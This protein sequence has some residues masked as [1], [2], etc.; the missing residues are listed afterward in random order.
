MPAQLK[1]LK[2][3]SLGMETDMIKFNYYGKNEEDTELFIESLNGY[4]LSNL[5]LHRLSYNDKYKYS[6]NDAYS[7][8]AKFFNS[9]LRSV[10]FNHCIFELCC[11]DK[12]KFYAGIS[13][14]VLIKNSSF[15][16]SSLRAS[17]Y[18]SSFK[19]C[20]F[21]NSDFFATLKKFGLKTTNL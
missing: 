19:M 11:F 21:T 14:R 18:E 10:I 8:N 16:N 5:H 3:M 2:L 12:T 13:R 17:F 7:H 15:C 1:M 6:F 20:Y 4:N 9:V